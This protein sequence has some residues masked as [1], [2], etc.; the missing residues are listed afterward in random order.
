MRYDFIARRPRAGQHAGK[1]SDA[2]KPIFYSYRALRFAKAAS[3]A[4]FGAINGLGTRKCSANSSTLSAFFVALARGVWLLGGRPKP[5]AH[6]LPRQTRR[7]LPLIP[8]PQLCTGAAERLPP[9]RPPPRHRWHNLAATQPA[10]VNN[11]VGCHKGSGSFAFGSARSGC[12][13]STRA[14]PRSPAEPAAWSPK[15]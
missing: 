5:L 4:A 2:F 7:H 3:G 8:F 14:C 12:P 13:R 6:V 15:V 10:L 9:S 1:F 11:A